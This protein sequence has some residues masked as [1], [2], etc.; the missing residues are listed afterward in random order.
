[1]QIKNKEEE[2]KL[3]Q[4]EI[5][6][7][8]QTIESLQLNLE[9]E[10]AERSRLDKELSKMMNQSKVWTSEKSALERHVSHSYY[11]LIVYLV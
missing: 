6:K 10:I 5:A 11:K 8:N 1:L 4:D 7:L 9:K 2:L 3:L